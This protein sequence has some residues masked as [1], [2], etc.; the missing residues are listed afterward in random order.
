MLLFISRA[1][2]LYL[3]LLIA[4]IIIWWMFICLLPILFLF[5]CRYTS[6]IPRSPICRVAKSCSTTSAWLIS[7]IFW[8]QRSP[9]FQ[10]ESIEVFWNWLRTSPG[11]RG[12]LLNHRWMLL[13]FTTPKWEVQFQL[14]VKLWIPS[15]DISTLLMFYN[16]WNLIYLLCH[17]VIS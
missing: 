12:L 14:L 16:V 2:N 10:G 6:K 8:F 3:Q 9:L 11:L 7:E 13:H 4:W 15:L 17:S 5:K 1:L